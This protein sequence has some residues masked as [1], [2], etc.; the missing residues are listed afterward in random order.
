MNKIN[1]NR[2][3]D[4]TTTTYNDNKIDTGTAIVL[5]HIVNRMNDNFNSV[6]PNLTFKINDLTNLG[7]NEAYKD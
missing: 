5:S 2:D 4:G 6:Q 3:V 1:M 7:Y